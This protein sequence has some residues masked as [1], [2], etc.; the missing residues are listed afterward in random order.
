MIYD[1][2]L[3]R[4]RDYKFRVCGKESIPFFLGSLYKTDFKPHLVKSIITYSY[5]RKI[6][7]LSDS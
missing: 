6:V 5:F 7:I 3:Q 2:G 4:Y 1:I